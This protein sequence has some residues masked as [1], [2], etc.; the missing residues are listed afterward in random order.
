[1]SDIKFGEVF[2][3]CPA[4]RPDRFLKAVQRSDRV[5]LDLEDAVAPSEK[6][7]ARE[8]LYSHLP[9][10]GERL[11]VRVNAI[12]SVWHNDDIE[13]LRQLRRHHGVST[14]IMLPKSC[15]ISQ[16]DELEDFEVIALCETASGIKNASA[17][18]S[19]P[20][21]SALMWGGEDLIADIG[22]RSSRNASG[23]YYPLVEQARSTVL[24]AAAAEGVPAIDAVHIDIADHDGLRRETKQAVD[25]GFFGKACIHPSHVEIIHEA[26]EPSKNER[27]WARHVLEAIDVAQGGVAT[28][29]GRMIDAPLLKQAQRILGAMSS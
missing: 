5:I 29:G 8:A 9:S 27:Q 21:C 23:K 19:A 4:N 13:A 22:G 28:L 25:I 17:L 24:L 11:I 2:L 14:T 20:N 7:L 26:F 12:D 6:K 18:A 15:D 1:M 3:F 10:L 16:L